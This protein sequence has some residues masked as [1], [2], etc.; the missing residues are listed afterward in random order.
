MA[1]TGPLPPMTIIA[2]D[3]ADPPHVLDYTSG[4]CLICGATH[5]DIVAKN[6]KCEPELSIDEPPHHK[7]DHND[8]L[9]G[10]LDVA[11]KAH[12]I[13]PA[14]IGEPEDWTPRYQER[15][16]SVESTS[17]NSPVPCP[18]EL[19]KRLQDVLREKSR[20]H[21]AA[22][23]AAFAAEPVKAEP[24]VTLYVPR[25]HENAHARLAVA[26]H[27]ADESGDAVHLIIVPRDRTGRLPDTRELRPADPHVR[28]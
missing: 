28:N 20:R 4:V 7:G 21:S 25:S 17:S 14:M 8:P 18:E 13:P 26:L 9:S 24:V 2:N 19:V 23:A 11:T 6:L 27:D 5:G 22:V 1:P 3:P 15:R 12:G 10:L 16:R